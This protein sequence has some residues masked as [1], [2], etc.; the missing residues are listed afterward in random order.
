[1]DKGQADMILERTQVRAPGEYPPLRLLVLCLG[2]C[3]SLLFSGA[4][5]LSFSKPLLIEQAV[6][7]IVRI[8]VQ[9]RIGAT[10]DNLS[11]SKI[12]GIAQSVL[13]QTELDIE[14]TRQ[15]IHQDLSGKVA[16]VMTNML[17]PDCECRQRLLDQVRQGEIEQYSA[18]VHIRERLTGLIESTYA[19]VTQNLMREFR[20][21]TVSNA[22]AFIL[23]GLIAIVRRG[24]ALQLIVPAVVL[25]GAVALTSSLYLFGQNWL[26][27]I[28]FGEY[29]GLA[30]IVY[31]AA[32]A[33]LLADLLFNRARVSTRIVN[34][35]LQS[36]GSATS[37]VPC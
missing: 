12:T 34:T 24:A 7:E 19:S 11:N 30:Y 6:R 3:G 20:I 31:L 9:R 28:V 32:V 22:M 14:Q 10:I 18:L 13:M 5:A 27:T 25:T 15:A 37:A 17:D 16:T 33:L 36:I 4:F 8:E 29:V 21:F 2:L 35:V 26:H 1:M 23:L